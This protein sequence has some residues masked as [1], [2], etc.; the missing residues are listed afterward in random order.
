MFTFYFAGCINAF[1]GSDGQG[2]YH[3]RQQRRKPIQAFI[4]VARMS[5]PFLALP[6]FFQ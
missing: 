3:V 5:G 1:V 6:A 4:R 2:I